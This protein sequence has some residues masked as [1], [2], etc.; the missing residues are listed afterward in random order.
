M[1][2][3]NWKKYLENSKSS[4]QI[5][6]V[7][8]PK[9]HRFSKLKMAD[10]IWR[11]KIRKRSKFNQQSSRLLSLLNQNPTLDFQNSK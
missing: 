2:D 7:A 5:F 11:T 10:P 3:L 9:S 4:L 1:A 6:K 8:E